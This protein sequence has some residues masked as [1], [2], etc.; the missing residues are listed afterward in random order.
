MYFKLMFLSSSTYQKCELIQT[1][2]LP[3]KDKTKTTINYK[4]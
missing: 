4:V 3:L 1:N 2:Y